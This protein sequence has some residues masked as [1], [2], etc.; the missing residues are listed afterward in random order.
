MKDDRQELRIQLRDTQNEL[1]HL[2]GHCER[3]ERLIRQALENRRDPMW[4]RN[5]R[6]WLIAQTPPP[7]RETPE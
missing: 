2:Y 6:S 7:T 3:A 4:E 5:A 1:D